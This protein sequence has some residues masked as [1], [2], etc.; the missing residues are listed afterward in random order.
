MASISMEVVL[1]DK[2]SPELDKI[3][4]ACGITVDKF[5]EY[6]KQVVE[7]QKM[8]EPHSKEVQKAFKIAQS[9]AEKAQKAIE[10][11]NLRVA[12]EIEKA[13]KELAKENLK[14]IKEAE[15]E[16]KRVEKEKLN[17]A[18]KSA[19]EAEMLAKNIEKENLK[20]L[21]STEKATKEM[22][23][24]LKDSFKDIEKIAKRTFITLGGIAG[25]SLK[26]FADYEYSIK[27]IQTISKDIYEK[28]SS[29]VRKMAYETGISSKELAQTL[30]D[31][32]Q[33]IQDDP[34][35]YTFMETV[36]KLAKAGFAE[37][38][39]AVNLLTS[40]ML[41][42]GYA[43]KDA[44]L[45]SS[46][47]LVAQTRG[48][49]TI[50]QLSDSLGTVMPMANQ[51]NLSFEEMLATI[52]TMTLGGIKTDQATTFLNNML[53][54]LAKADT[55][56]SKTFTKINNGIDFKNFLTMGGTVLEAIIKLEEE[57]KKGNKSLVDM[58][59]N[60]RSTLGAGTL[61]NLAEPFKDILKSIS[62]TTR[63]HLNENFKGINNDT[64]SNL[65]R[66]KE[67]LSQFSKEI[68]NRV[69]TDLSDFL[70]L[71][72][73]IPF[74]EMFKKER[75]DDIYATGKAIFYVVGSIEALAYAFR[76]GAI[77][78]SVK[79]VITALVSANPILAG[80][81]ATVGGLV[82]LYNSLKSDDERSKKSLES[83]REANS[84]WE[85]RK[86]L[87]EAVKKDLESGIINP[88][89]LVV[90]K[91]FEDLKG[92]LEEAKRMLE[93]A[94]NTE[95]FEKVLATLL[96]EVNKLN[97]E[98]NKMDGKEINIKINLDGSE[99]GNA[100]SETVGV[101]GINAIKVGEIYRN[102]NNKVYKD[103]SSLSSAIGEAKK[104]G[105]GDITLDIMKKGLK[106]LV[107]NSSNT[108]K[109]SK[110][111]KSSSDPFK[112]LISE[113]GA[114]I[115]FELSID[116]KIAKL[117]EAKGRFKKH[118]DEINVAIT[119]FKIDELGRKI[120]EALEGVSLESHKYSKDE[121][122]AKYEKAKSYYLE[123]KAL[124]KNKEEV[125][126]IEKEIEKIDFSIFK[127]NFN[128]LV[129]GIKEKV[130]DL[131][132]NK[133]INRKEKQKEINEIKANIANAQTYLNENKDKVTAGDTEE[134]NKVIKDLG[135]NINDVEEGV[136]GSGKDIVDAISNLSSAFNNLGSITGSKTI[137]GIG[138]TLSS[139]SN[140]GSAM[141]GIK[142]AGGIGTISGIFSKSG[143]VSGATSLGALAG[144]V[145]AGI[146]LVSTI[147]SI[148][149]S[150][151]KKKA[152]KIDA[153]NKE[154]ENRYQ[155]QVKAMQQ[156]TEALRQNSERIKSFSDRMLSDISKNPTLKSILGGEHNFTA[157]YEAMLQ[158][159][160][161]NDIDAIEKG[162]KKYR[163]G[164]RKKRKDTFTAVKIGEADLLKYLGFDKTE[165]DLFTDD[166]MRQLK[167][168]IQ[169]IGHEDLKKA[170]KRNLTQ[171]TIEEWKAQ[172]NEFVAQIDYLEKEKKELFRGS[173]L[174][175]FIGVEYKAE[176][177]LIAEYTEQFKQLGLVGEQYSETIKE[178][179][180]NN[181]VFITSMQDVRASTIDGLSDGTGGFLSSMKGYFEKIFK[182]A[183]SV[184]YDVMF[185]EYDSYFNE[186]YKNI[187]EKLVDIKRTGKIN[188]NNLFD[189]VDFN[190]LKLAEITEIEAKKSLDTLK[191][192]LVNSGV[193]ISLINKILPKSD[194][195]DRINELKNAL[196]NAMNTGLTDKSFFSFTKTL[197]ESLY[198]SMKSSLVK[199]FSE[200]SL[201]QGMIQKFIK[202]EN[203]QTK[204][205]SAKS[206][207]EVFSISEEILKKFGYELEASGYGG[208]DAINKV[209]TQDNQLGHAYYQDK[210][211][212]INL[213]FNFTYQGD[214][215]GFD[216]YEN[217]SRK[218]W[219]GFMK[220]W[221]KLPVAQR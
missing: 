32:V 40:T 24:K 154:N 105:A 71:T 115:K 176:K 18:R 90:S 155:E 191:S 100:L 162:S 94:P 187:S 69:A 159:K 17:E 150:S 156:L 151:G 51:V 201:Y 161:F 143:F 89:L 59:G 172:I 47:F 99:I 192:E 148:F 6:V 21:K 61:S 217:K 20:A 48:N 113:L 83:L 53:K 182:N 188:F 212:E 103:I 84:E 92:K 152:A 207:K 75:I 34:N 95:D 146:G 112:E 57:A 190:Q 209:N 7:V 131:K 5:K 1:S 9:E 114:K 210:E 120:S 82:Y 125:E 42:Y 138:G 218:M 121:T 139:I 87:L 50:K 116:D 104:L 160:H 168:A 170:T 141:K 196:S 149:G 25:Y 27:K 79:T 12:K 22:N 54:E 137:A 165:L 147:G 179:A 65:G 174:E 202:A 184:I 122:I 52:T 81:S 56:V 204:L 118:I 199:A 64:K 180:K 206:F 213:T 41:S 220:E 26:G 96:N 45:L 211:K 10:K 203:F 73:D 173:T 63:E 68:G 178:M 74:D 8:L 13:Q 198:E 2:A 35:K 117:E 44:E 166:E 11:E 37:S 123:K 106:N 76:A 72:K 215:Y 181:Q 185:S 60:I 136:K 107:S 133:N 109:K 30:Y 39:D 119:N 49:T 195:N 129:D 93:E 70:N 66:L 91:D 14:T 77:L 216:E 126:K 46:K 171:S 175:S 200:S 101:A 153:N 58:F 127:Q 145:V 33:V 124:T 167:G 31:A 205:E 15:R 108:S 4:K 29:K 135:K 132:K 140:I 128:S 177:E 67:T 43:V 194:F 130:D 111:S 80:I 16:F 36:S 28:I 102:F 164:F 78:T 55:E 98:L 38:S 134:A 3:A 186:V 163:S 110:G 157:I 219:Q 62:E 88:D 86:A 23:K 221:Q 193:D 142:D 144:G 214:I 197:G 183:T 189:D 169:N 158:G 208:F 97:D 85:N 19:K